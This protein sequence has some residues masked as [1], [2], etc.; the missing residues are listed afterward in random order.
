MK[1]SLLI[2]GIIVIVCLI[3]FGIFNNVNST[4]S[5]DQEDIYDVILFWGQSNMVGT[6]SSV[7]ENRYNP[8]D[9]DSVK[10]FSEITG[11]D[12]EILKNNGANRDYVNIEQEANT[13]F[14]YMYNSNSL[15]EIK[16][17]RTSLGEHL[18]FSATDNNGYPTNL[19]L[20]SDSPTWGNLSVQRSNGINMIPEF[21]KTY[22]KNT[23]HK[24]V[25]VFSAYGGQPIDRLLPYNDPDNGASG[26]KYQYEAM[27]LKYQSAIQYMENNNLRIGRKI[28]V[29]FQ[30]ESDVWGNTSTERY[31]DIFLRVHNNIKNDLG[32]QKGAICET[33]VTLGTETMA[34][35]NQVHDAQEQ[36]IAENDDI[37][38]G[39]SYSYD[40][41]VPSESDYNNCNTKIAFDKSGNKLSYNVALQNASYSVDYS[42]NTVHFT[43]AALSQVGKEAA[44]AYSSIKSIEIG[45]LPTKTE[46]IQNYENLDLTGAKLKINYNNINEDEIEITSEMVKGFD[47]SKTGTQTITVEYRGYKTEFNV[48]INAKEITK[49][50][51][52]SIPSKIEYI[53]NYEEIDLTGGTI[54]ITYND[55]TKEEIKIQKEMISGFDN[56]KIGTQTITVE[57]EGYKT[58][59]NVVISA[60][61]IVKVVVK[62][63]P[64]KTEYIQNY[65]E[66]DLTGG[67][68]EITYNDETK[69]EIEMQKE[70]ISGFNNRKTGTQTITVEYKGYKT[71]F[72][73]VINEKE[74]TKVVLKSIPSK[75]EYIQNY[76]KL[77]PTGGKIEIEYNDTSKETKDITSEMISGFD[78]TKLGKQKLTV[79]YEGKTVEYEVKIVAKQIKAIRIKKIPEKVEYTQNYDVLD[80]AGGELEIVYNDTSTSLIEITSEMVK[81][82]DNTKL[83]K[84]TLRVEYE[85]KTVEYEVT[86]V[87]KKIVS[88]KMGKLPQKEKYIQ[89]YEEIDLTGGT[90]E[91]TYNDE[92]KEEIKIKKEMISGFDNTKLGKQ[93]IIV[94]YGEYETEFDV[95]IEAKSVV[96]VEIIKKPNKVE[97]IQDEENIEVTGG[98]IKI[99]YNDESEEEK[100]IT[101]EMISGFDN[102]KV[103]AVQITVKYEGY[104]DTYNVEIIA[105]KST[106][107]N[108]E[109]NTKEEIKE[110]VKESGKAEDSTIADTIIPKAGGRKTIIGLIIIFGIIMIVAAYQK[111]KYKDVK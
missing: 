69:E 106:E 48:V 29:V 45:S 87:E 108:N 98:K 14:E 1:K 39:S 88:I 22:Y 17:S 32:I 27:K 89:N 34:K 41:Y 54:E 85:G 24:V 44:E 83:G 42:G 20:D 18:Y 76:E 16:G 95:E 56:S 77:D 57:Y 11:I 30:G 50:V 52:K 19:T 93:K 79:T 110:E 74:I 7:A 71:E 65:E 68:I 61:E 82:F 100:E 28:Y 37:I 31:K 10:N 36:L 25:A 105:K 109:N 64:N 70:M 33:S 81:G 90:I 99:Y 62:N 91:I 84:Q 23:G 80:T 49:V 6:S 101:K 55:E 13:V 38:L 60:K 46:Y 73:V 58:E 78:N 51:L 104:T 94:S 103:G 92:T 107:N 26:N 47:N 12:Q 66:I 63:I 72:N 59:F 5:S 43:S 40:R 53:Q 75:K 97:Y 67:T 102:K 2:L 35:V 9:L 86:I 3:F 21:C 15:E 4:A 96:K 111:N 8:S